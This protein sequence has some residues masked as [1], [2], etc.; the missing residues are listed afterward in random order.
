VTSTPFV[1]APWS[2]PAVLWKQQVTAPTEEPLTVAEAKL[3]AALPGWPE[4]DPRDALMEDYIRAA[5]MQVEHDT[6]LALLT[7][8]W[9]VTFGESPIGAIVPLPSQTQPTQS[10]EILPDAVRAGPTVLS[11][12]RYV[13]GQVEAFVWPGA[14]PTLRI[15]A[16][17]PDAATFRREA[18]SLYHAV[19][20]LVAHYA[21]IGRDLA[22]IGETAAQQES[23]RTIYGYEEAI[24]PHRLIWVI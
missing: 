16:G 13:P 12:W 19:G 3:R 1:P 4:G 18:P 9:E 10:I 22:V 20:L 5:R 8:T 14:P 7:Q 2:S 24:G 6:G 17:W 21:T 15:V 11:R 23:R